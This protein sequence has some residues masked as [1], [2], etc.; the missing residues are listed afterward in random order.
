MKPENW[1][2]G[3]ERQNLLIAVS[4]FVLM[5][6]TGFVLGDYLADDGY[7]RPDLYNSESNVTLNPDNRE[8]TVR[9]DNRSVTLYYENWNEFRAFL[10]TENMERMIN[11]TSDGQRRTVSEVAVVGN[12]AYRFYFRYRDDPEEFDEDFIQLYRIQQIQ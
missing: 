7:E 1:E 4:A 5:L 9:F 12:E 6:G 3:L 10:E 2:L 8:E 11:T